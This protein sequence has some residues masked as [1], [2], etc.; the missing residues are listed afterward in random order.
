MKRRLKA[1]WP[2]LA[3]L[4]AVLLLCFV[5]S[6]KE[7]VRDLE[8]KLLHGKDFRV[9]TQAALALGASGSKKAVDPLC[10]GL[11][12]SHD[13]VRAASAAALGKLSKGG[14][15]CLKDRL[16]DEKSRN[17]KKMIEKAIKLLEEAASGPALSA[18]TK[19]YIAIKQTD[20]R[21]GRG[22]SEI[23]DLVH[24]TIKQVLGSQKGFVLAPAGEKADEAKR[25]LRKHPHVYGYLLAPKVHKPQYD[26]GKVV[27]NVE[28]TIYGYPDSSMQ[29]SLSR[30]AGFTGV[31]SQDKGKENKLI[32]SASESATEEFARMAESAG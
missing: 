5:A 2:A 15:K 20:D 16:E 30:T 12:D 7:S 29:G 21:T 17:V 9:R 10:K 32:K 24:R 14:V 3:A 1:A 13:A 27:I 19:Y 23:N 22:G 18:S 4:I 25:R 31:D 28:L 8:E 6:A 26:G 11:K